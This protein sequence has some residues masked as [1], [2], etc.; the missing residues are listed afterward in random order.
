LK[1]LLSSSAIL[2][3][4]CAGTTAQAEDDWYARVFA[5]YPI[6]GTIDA[7]LT[8]LGNKSGFSPDCLTTEPLAAI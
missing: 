2:A 6:I 8:T 5:G 3:A 4:L 1:N 7:N